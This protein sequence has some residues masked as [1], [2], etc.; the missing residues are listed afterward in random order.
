ME[1]NEYKQ[2]CKKIRDYL[3]ASRLESNFTDKEDIERNHAEYSL[4]VALLHPY[5]Y[6]ND[7]PPN[8]IDAE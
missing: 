3:V 5:L 7:L 4:L 1:Y 2:M 8:S 6:L